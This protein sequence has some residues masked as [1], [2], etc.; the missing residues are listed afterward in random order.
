MR[1]ICVFCTVSLKILEFADRSRWLTVGLLNPQ[2]IGEWGLLA[3]SPDLGEGWLEIELHSL[4][5]D[6]DSFWVGE[7]IEMLEGECTQRGQRA[8]PSP[9]TWLYSFLPLSH[10]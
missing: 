4:D 6:S 3:P 2:V 1:N 10:F 5:S 9:H 7:H 8:A